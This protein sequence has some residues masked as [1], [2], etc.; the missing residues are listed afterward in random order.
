MNWVHDFSA[1]VLCAIDH[2]PVVG[3]ILG[4]ANWAFK[5]LAAIFLVGAIYW[6]KNR[7]GAK[8]P[9]D[10]EAGIIQSIKTRT[11]NGRAAVVT[12]LGAI[13]TIILFTS[14]FAT[15]MLGTGSNLDLKTGPTVLP[16][17]NYRIAYVEHGSKDG[18]EGYFSLFQQPL[19]PGVWDKEHAFYIFAP[20][21]SIPRNVQMKEGAIV[22]LALFQNRYIVGAEVKDADPHYRRASL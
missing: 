6:A 22:S 11:H 21:S 13:G 18:V 2:I 1:W 12:F 4:E 17:N 9:L 16:S 3:A 14:A 8:R 19:G 7:W 15:G 5:I 10:P 20:E